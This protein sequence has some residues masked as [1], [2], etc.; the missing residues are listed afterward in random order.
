M[1]FIST[2]A[3]LVILNVISLLC[4]KRH[5]GALSQALRRKP[6]VYETLESLSNLGL[7]PTYYDKV[8]RRTVRL[9]ACA[10]VIHI[11]DVKYGVVANIASE[12]RTP[13]DFV[14]YVL[15]YLSSD[16]PKAGSH[17]VK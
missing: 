3:A 15:P 1:L 8:R 6:T 2:I 16:E 9:R 5:V 17:T 11:Y 12:I 13:D 4:W 7:P 10:G 14:I